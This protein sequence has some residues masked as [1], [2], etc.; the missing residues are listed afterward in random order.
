M[1]NQWPTQQ[2]QKGFGEKM[3]EWLLRTEINFFFPSVRVWRLPFKLSRCYREKKFRLN[4]RYQTFFIRFHLFSLN[5]WSDDTQKS[6]EKSRKVLVMQ[7]ANSSRRPHSVQNAIRNW[8][9]MSR[10]PIFSIEKFNLNIL[11]LA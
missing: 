11:C 8:T 1:W 3:F 10:R 7:S 2:R 5:C 6:F 4:E 9:E